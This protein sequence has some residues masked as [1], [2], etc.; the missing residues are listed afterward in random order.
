L[1]YLIYFLGAEKSGEPRAQKGASGD[2][3]GVCR[4]VFLFDATR[5]HPNLAKS[6]LPASV[7]WPVLS[8]LLTLSII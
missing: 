5:P 3:D 1:N 2:G 6:G 4:K 7:C 8:A